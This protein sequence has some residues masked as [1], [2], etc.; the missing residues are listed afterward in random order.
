MIVLFCFPEIKWFLEYLEATTKKT[1]IFKL[2]PSKPP[3][4]VC[5]VTV[6][7]MNHVY[8]H[9]REINA[10]NRYSRAATRYSITADLKLVEHKQYIKT[11]SSFNPAVVNDYINLRFHMISFTQRNGQ[12]PTRCVYSKPNKGQRPKKTL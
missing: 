8:V 7:I 6:Y 9:R 5:S 4:Y 3:G 1:L 2:R 12:S 10:G 11:A